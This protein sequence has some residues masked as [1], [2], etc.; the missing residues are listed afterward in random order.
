M[1]SE[2]LRGFYRRAGV[3]VYFIGSLIFYFSLHYTDSLWG[4]FFLLLGLVLA[5]SDPIVLLW[6]YKK[7][8]TRASD[9][10][11]L[12]D[13]YRA[14][15]LG[16]LACL[17][18]LA[19]FFI[20]LPID[21]LGGADNSFLGR[22]RLFLLF[23]F[24][25][26]YTASLLYRLMLSLSDKAL[27]LSRG[28]Q[29]Q[30]QRQQYLKGAVASILALFCVLVFLNY[31]SYIR[32]PS[33][34]LSPG[35]YS[36]RENSR[37]VIRSLEREVNVYAFLPEIQAVRLRQSGFSSPEL[38]KVTSDVRLILEQLSS[39]NS[40]IKLT[41]Y[42]A[43]IDS[44]DSNEFGN[45]NNGTI[46]FRCLKQESRN[47]SLEE[48]PYVERKV[49]VNNVGDLKKMEKEILKALVYVAS[50]QKNIYFTASNGE[51]YD[52]TGAASRSSGIESF[53]QQLRFYNLKLKRLDTKSGWPGKALPEDA[54]ALAIIA[55]TTPFG[56]KARDE[57]LSYLKKGGALFLSI[58]VQEGKENFDWLLSSLGMERER[59]RF[60][61]SVLTNTNF[62]GLLVSD[63]FQEH[64]I[65][66]S[67]KKLSGASVLMP[68]HA[69]F[70][71][72]EE[73]KDKKRSP[74]PKEKE[75]KD[76]KKKK[77]KIPK[78]RG[79]V[80]KLSELE[81]HIFLYSPYNSYVDENR[82]GRR[83]GKEKNAR[84]ILALAYEKK[85]S[86]ASPR[87]VIFSGTS[88]LSERGIRYPVAN[89]NPLFATDSLFWLLES[90]LTASFTPLVRPTHNVQVTEE[91][92][93]RLILIGMFLFPIGVAIALGGALFYYRRRSAKPSN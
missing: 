79:P 56:E 51:L 48:K 6:I 62:S 73:K 55:P 19:R 9:D 36:F 37:T 81:P 58:N 53:K 1:I 33:L 63:N 46:V 34:D 93:W 69:Y 76:K 67:I 4:L 17:C 78:K 66:D 25:I 88:W 11:R 10:S 89:R 39:I 32:N 5:L 23:F 24:L 28:T 27:S 16:L 41:F 21:K 7:K 12:P 92:K 35:Y 43:D 54:A 40:K 42:N 80:K 29:L 26:F 74:P 31:L 77:E 71:K 91:L 52:T 30:K 86:P 83:D 47:L 85:D 3:S 87:L 14:W 61:P 57:I 22:L 68:Q 13:F 84:R 60:I 64:S 49:Y 44:Y 8:E 38:Y 82:N 59:Y 72:I 18:Y 15:I 70:E 2:F 75:K 90:P 65:T 20:E 45:I 50:P